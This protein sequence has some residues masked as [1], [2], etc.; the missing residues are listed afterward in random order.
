MS[1][2]EDSNIRDRIATLRNLACKNESNHRWF[3]VTAGELLELSNIWIGIN[4]KHNRYG[5][6]S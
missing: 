6:T 3:I 1:I 4:L 2:M 5:I